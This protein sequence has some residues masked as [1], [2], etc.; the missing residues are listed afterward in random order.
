MTCNFC[1]TEDGFNVI[2]FSQAEELLGTIKKEGFKN[3]VFGGGEP[4][5]WPENLIALTKKAKDEGF[6]VQVGTNAIAL[7]ENFEFIPTVDR[8]VLPLESAGADIHNSM[9][10]YKHKHH[11]IILHSLRKLKAAHKSVTVSTIVTRMNYQGLKELAYFLTQLNSPE[12]FIHAWHLYM[13][14]PQGRGGS[15]NASAL[16]INENIYERVVDEVK[17]LDCSFSVYKRRDMYSSKTVDFFW[18]Q[19]GQIRRG[20]EESL[21]I[22]T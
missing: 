8:Y 16:S 9:R 11:Q 1:I 20:S 2:S 3:V 19:D 17:Q 10:F 7:P 6:F 15:I 18:V 5:I 21:R 12:R 13:F 22:C 4:F 14:L